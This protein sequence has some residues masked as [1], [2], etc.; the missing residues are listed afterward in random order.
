MAAVS[1]SIARSTS[2]AVVT[3]GGMIRSDLSVAAR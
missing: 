3:S 1:V 2:A